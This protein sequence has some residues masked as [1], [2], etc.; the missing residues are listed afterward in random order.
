M[1]SDKKL[2]ALASCGIELVSAIVVGVFIG[3]WLDKHFDKS[4]LFLILFSLLGCVSGYLNVVRIIE[5]SK[6]KKANK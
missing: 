5:K 4:P 3:I 1:K 6:T 2:T